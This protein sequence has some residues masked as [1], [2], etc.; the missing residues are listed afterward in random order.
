MR[1]CAKIQ[2]LSDRDILKKR[3]K[4]KKKSF[5]IESLLYNS[6]WY[7]DRGGGRQRA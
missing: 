4:G 2:S 1:P 3:L 7:S 6:F 5:L